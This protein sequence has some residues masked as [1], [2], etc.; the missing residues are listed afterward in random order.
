MRFERRPAGRSDGGT[1]PCLAARGSCIAF[2]SLKSGDVLSARDVLSAGDVLR[3]GDEG[4]PAPN[5]CANRL[6]PGSPSARRK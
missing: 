4:R 1:Q 2:P 3:T 6:Q 5:S